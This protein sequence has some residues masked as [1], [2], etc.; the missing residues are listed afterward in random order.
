[1]YVREAC[2]LVS[3]NSRSP[4]WTGGRAPKKT[5]DLKETQRRSGRRPRFFKNRP[6]KKK[7]LFSPPTKRTGGLTGTKKS[8]PL[9]TQHFDVMYMTVKHSQRLQEHHG[10]KHAAFKLKCR[11]KNKIA[12]NYRLRGSILNYIVVMDYPI[13]VVETCKTELQ[14]CLVCFTNVSRAYVPSSATVWVSQAFELALLS[15]AR[16][17]L[18][19]LQRYWEKTIRGSQRRISKE[20]ICLREKSKLYRVVRCAALERPVFTLF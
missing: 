13:N 4:K 14:Y 1:M 3:V 10:Y 11:F 15:P 19:L 9:C 18:L 17:V 7:T 2:F 12:T 8:R 20:H 5:W 6:F 16:N